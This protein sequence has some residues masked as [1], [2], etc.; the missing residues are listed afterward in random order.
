MSIQYNTSKHWFWFYSSGPI[1]DDLWR[2]SSDAFIHF[3]QTCEHP[4]ISLS[5]VTDD[6]QTPSPLQREHVARAVRLAD[7]SRFAA[8]AFV[9]KSM[10]ARGVMTAIHWLSKPIYPQKI[11][12]NCESAY[13][14]LAPHTTPE[15]LAALSEDFRQKTGIHPSM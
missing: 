12:S 14:W 9:M 10:M 3:H 4:A 7:P 13:T 15:I 2:E 5:Y 6:A 11:F 1:D 8:Q